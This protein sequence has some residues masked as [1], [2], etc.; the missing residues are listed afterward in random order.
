MTDS[1]FYDKFLSYPTIAAISASVCEAKKEMLTLALLPYQENCYRIYHKKIHLPLLSSRISNLVK[2]ETEPEEC[3]HVDKTILG[4]KD[5]RNTQV[6]FYQK[7][8]LHNVRN[9][10]FQIPW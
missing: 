9:I 4:E 10:V 6:Q 3:C 7:S 1:S 2:W 8:S 5:N